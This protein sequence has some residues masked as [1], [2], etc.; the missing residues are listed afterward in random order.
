MLTFCDRRRSSEQNVKVHAPS[1][2]EKVLLRK[3]KMAELTRALSDTVDLHSGAS[4][5]R[6][7]RL[8]TNWF[9]TGTGQWIIK[10]F[11]FMDF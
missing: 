9:L 2:T 3:R 7:L 5:F 11:G 4:S 10:G 1:V 8:R 6:C